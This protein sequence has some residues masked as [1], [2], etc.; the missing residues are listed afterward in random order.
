MA[1][2]PSSAEPKKKAEEVEIDLDEADQVD[3][4]TEIGLPALAGNLTVISQLSE[5]ESHTER[6]NLMEKKKNF[7]I[8]NHF[9]KENHTETNQLS[10]IESLTARENHTAIN[11]EH[12]VMLQVD[13][14]LVQVDQVLVLAQVNQALD[15][16]DQDQIDNI[17]KEKR[18]RYREIFPFFYIKMRSIPIEISKGIYKLYSRRSTYHLPFFQLRCH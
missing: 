6:G 3:Q 1:K 17:Q 12:L 9:E 11:P 8:G 13:Q 16:V 14:I 18:W 15:Q 5:I 10:E 7:E 4:D 2:K